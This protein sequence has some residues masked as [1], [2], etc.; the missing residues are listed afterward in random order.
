MCSL[1]T[2]GGVLF[3]FL[4]LVE[5]HNLTLFSPACHGEPSRALCIRWVLTKQMLLIPS[6]TPW[7]WPRWLGLGPCAGLPN[8]NQGGA[9][10]ILDSYKE[11]WQVNAFLLLW[12]WEYFTLGIWWMKGWTTISKHNLV[13]QNMYIIPHSKEMTFSLS[14]WRTEQVWRSVSSKTWRFL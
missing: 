11:R 6:T 4:S 7:K 14:L 12:L 13:K 2:G 10:D 8:G 3:I 5:L 9:G 1:R